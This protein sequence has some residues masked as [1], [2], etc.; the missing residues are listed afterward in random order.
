MSNKKKENKRLSKADR[1]PF[2]MIEAGD[3]VSLIVIANVKVGQRHTRRRFKKRI[4]FDSKNEQKRI[5]K[6]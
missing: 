5:K 3:F 2:E 6:R 1:L 4:R